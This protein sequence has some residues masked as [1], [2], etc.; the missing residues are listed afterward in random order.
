MSASCGYCSNPLELAR[1]ADELD[2]ATWLRVFREAAALG[3]VQVN[4]T[5]GEPLVRD[6]LEQLVEGA[7][8][9]ELYMNLITSGIPLRR[10]RLARLRRLGLDSVQLSVQDV[11]PAGSD[12]IAGRSFDRKRE[13]AG[14]SRR[15][16]CR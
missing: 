10:E 1:H 12:R 2:T 7:R 16:G 14:G 3:V 13:V 11:T 9:L 6:D 8:S 4:L 15:S 5:G